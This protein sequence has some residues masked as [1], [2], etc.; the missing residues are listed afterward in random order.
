MI[1]KI[2]KYGRLLIPKKLREAR[3]LVAGTKFEFRWND[4]SGELV[5]TPMISLS[6]PV[7]TLDEFGIPSF[8]FGIDEVM[9]YDF[10]AAIKKDRNY[11][12]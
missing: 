4:K 7:S 11:G 8:D 12:H 10:G 9:H 1:T 6:N 5:L 3:G 2:D